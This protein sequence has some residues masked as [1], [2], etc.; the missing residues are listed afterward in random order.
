MATRYWQGGDGNWDT[1][2]NWGGT[3]PVDGDTAIF[4]EGVSIGVNAGLDQGGVDLALMYIHPR[5]TGSI[6]SSGSP[7]FIAGNLILHEGPGALYIESDAGGVTDKIDELRINCTN[8]STIVEI[9]SNA[10]D[11]G[12]VVKIVVDRGN[13]TIKTNISLDAAARIECG[14][15]GNVDG[16]VALAIAAGAG[17]LATLVQRGGHIMSD[18]IITALYKSAGMLIQDTAKITT[19]DIFGGVLEYNHRVVGGDAIALRMHGGTLDLTQTAD[20]KTIS[21][22][23]THDG[24]TLIYNNNLHT[25]TSWDPRGGMHKLVG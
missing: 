16:D 9:G 22:L 2:A 3:K 8:A 20:E 19:G 12:D 10:A 15:K 25:F 1:V 24:S 13:V 7:L 14:H 21:T 17:T 18:D 11:A 23:E 6:G 4:P 5:F